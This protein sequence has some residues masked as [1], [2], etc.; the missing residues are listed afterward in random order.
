MA[1]T[2]KSEFD[3][4]NAPSLGEAAGMDEL[5]AWFIR[6]VLPLEAMLIQFLRRAGRSSS[7]AEDLRQDLYERVF[8]AAREG[9]PK[10]TRAFV[11]TVARN[12][13]INRVKHEQVV[14]FT[15]VESLEELS[16]AIDEPA[17]DRVVIARQEL[18]RLQVALD[19]LPERQR[20]AIVLRKVEGLSIREI[21]QRVGSAERTVEEHLTEGVR[22][23]ASILYRDNLDVEQSG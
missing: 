23:L 4:P 18:R 22:T 11:F 12:L 9:I 20:R 14:P 8:D 3:E 21:A 19:K 6:E 13:L 5:E 7:D 2:P 17:P 16:L 1:D 10:S 15:S